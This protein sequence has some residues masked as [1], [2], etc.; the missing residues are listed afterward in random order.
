MKEEKNV[1]KI[2]INLY[3]ACCCCQ[4]TPLTLRHAYVKD[5][6]DEMKTEM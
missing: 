2:I 1:I 4:H 6:T 5:P 3:N